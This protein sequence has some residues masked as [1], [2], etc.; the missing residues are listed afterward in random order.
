LSASD[1]DFFHTEV[2]GV[3]KM[4]PAIEIHDMDSGDEYFVGTCT[5]MNESEEIDACGRRR[6]AWLRAM[7]QKGS[8]VKVAT[9]DGK[10]TGFLHVIPIEFCP[11]GP[12][13]RD[14]LAIPCL[15]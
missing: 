4:K 2:A 5:H 10:R 9:L 15:V 12:L 3:N 8:Q 7:H 1:Q 11:W 6:L 13:G 14:L